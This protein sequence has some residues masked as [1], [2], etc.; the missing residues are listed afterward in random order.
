VG[1][2]EWMRSNQTTGK[3]D[4]GRLYTSL[5]FGLIIGV[6]IAGMTAQWW[7][8]TVGVLAGAA[9][10]YIGMKFRNGSDRR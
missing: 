2:V 9:T 5:I 3:P 1:S 7:W 10:G 8:A 6:V 4:N